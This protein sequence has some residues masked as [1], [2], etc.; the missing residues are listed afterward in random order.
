M[1]KHAI[2]QSDHKSRTRILYST[3]PGDVPEDRRK[4]QERLKQVTV[5]L[6]K[7]QQRIRA[8]PKGFCDGPVSQC[9]QALQVSRGPK[10]P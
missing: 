3:R 4:Y 1:G 6:K 2:R 5:L 9:Y 10:T 8:V 7:V